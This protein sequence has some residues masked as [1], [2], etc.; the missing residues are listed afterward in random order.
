MHRSLLKGLRS[1]TGP[2]FPQV[3]LPQTQ[4]SATSRL[5]RGSFLA[6]NLFPKQLP[7]VSLKLVSYGHPFREREGRD[8]V[9][10]ECP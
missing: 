9:Q 10:G 7:V 4:R 5:A 6:R 2:L 1:I 3:L 8:R